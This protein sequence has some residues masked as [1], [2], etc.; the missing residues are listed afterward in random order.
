[1]YI[2]VVTCTQIR[3]VITIYNWNTV[4]DHSVD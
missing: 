2:I 1:V 3:L 4:R